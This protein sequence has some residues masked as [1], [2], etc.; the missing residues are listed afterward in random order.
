MLEPTNTSSEKRD[1]NDA[2]PWLFK[3]GQV[4]NPKGRPRL[5]TQL[6]QALRAEGL[7]SVQ[8]LVELRDN[9]KNPANV[10]MACANSLLD[11]GFGK[12]REM[13]EDLVQE[14]QELLADDALQQLLE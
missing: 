9:K 2:K 13:K 12:P 3:P 6:R 11:R 4:A 8:T 14:A 7:A 1:E 5:D 10:R